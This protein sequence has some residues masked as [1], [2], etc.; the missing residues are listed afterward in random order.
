MGA[1]CFLLFSSS[2]TEGR[3]V[4]ALCYGQRS[5]ESPWLPAVWPAVTF[6]PVSSVFVFSLGLPTDRCRGHQDRK[7][8]SM[9]LTPR[10]Q[11]QEPEKAKDFGPNI[12]TVKASIF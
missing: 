12:E 7:W 5:Q 1:Q 3:F 11:N 8:L 10:R 2:S 4:S 6:P 9:K